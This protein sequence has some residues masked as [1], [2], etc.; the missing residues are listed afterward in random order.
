MGLTHR[1]GEA[2]GCA[3]CVAGDA[4]PHKRHNHNLRHYWVHR[5]A[6][7]VNRADM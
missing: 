7:S 4:A 1:I 3:A 6:V 5:R 2:M